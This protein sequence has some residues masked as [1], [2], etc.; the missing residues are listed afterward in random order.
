MGME[1]SDGP[2]HA[3][4]QR[5]ELLA[6]FHPKVIE[7]ARAAARSWAGPASVPF[8]SLPATLQ[9]HGSKLAARELLGLLDKFEATQLASADLAAVP[10][11]SACVLA[12]GGKYTG[13][14]VR[15]RRKRHGARRRV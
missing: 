14:M 4:S 1:S 10:L 7:S 8:T 13:L 9:W 3:A 5:L 6:E 15:A 2:G 11:V 12:A